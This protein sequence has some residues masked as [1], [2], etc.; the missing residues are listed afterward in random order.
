MHP[1]HFFDEPLAQQIF[2]IS[3]SLCD[4]SY[5][6]GGSIRDILLGGRQISDLDIAVEGD[7]F[8]IAREVANRLTV[9]SSFVAL[10][11]D[12][13]TGRIVVSEPTNMTVDISSFKGPD[14]TQDLYHRD[15]TINSIAVHLWDIIS[16]RVSEAIIDPLG[17]R[18]D[19][20]RKIIR[21]SSSNSFTEDPLRMLRA[22]RFSSQLGF[23]ICPEARLGI[24]KSATLIQN[25]SGE[26]IRDELEIVFRSNRSAK[27]VE[28]MADTSL[29]W[30]IFPE[31]RPSRG[32]EQNAFHHLDVWG[33]TV[34]AL[35]NLETIIDNLPV[36]LGPFS[37]KAFN[38]ICEQPVTGR[39]RQW[40]LKLAVLFHDSGKP[41]S[42]HVDENGRRRFIGH[43][44]VSKTL[45][46]VAGARLKLGSRELSEVSSWI[47]GHMRPSILT[48]GNPSQRAIVR[49]VHRFGTHFMGLIIL[50]LADL[51]AAKGPARDLSDLQ[52][53]KHGVR[54][55]IELF[56]KEEETPIIPLLD[57]FDMMSEFGLEQGPH[58]G[59][60][61]RWLVTEQSLGLTRNR[62]QAK[63]AIRRYLKQNPV[64][65]KKERT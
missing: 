11:K 24:E 31:L 6:V 44:K 57:G 30:E 63:E 7:G 16:G 4:E 28:Q 33:H 17:G 15:F 59:S 48:L 14:I 25:V 37:E 38:Y 19:L 50:Y 22:F 58:L 55:A 36:F 2:Q 13:R 5:L 40:L 21:M 53:A 52:R 18:E 49:L 65:Q 32:F 10:D 51:L 64:T 23:D 9:K 34:D 3:L 42:L 41:F 26:R 29:L 47:E 61:I 1:A 56:L 20:K 54:R 39:S 12:R 43:E 8:E 27:I 46:L 60:I 35:E 45:F 62:E